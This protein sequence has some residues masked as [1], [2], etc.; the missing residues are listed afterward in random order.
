[1]ARKRP[2]G[3]ASSASRTTGAATVSFAPAKGRRGAAAHDLI[4]RLDRNRAAAVAAEATDDKEA[5]R[6]ALLLR[7]RAIE[8]TR[9][10]LAKAKAE[11]SV[12]VGPGVPMQAGEGSHAADEFDGKPG[13]VVRGAA[14]K[15][16]AKAKANQSAVKKQRT[17]KSSNAAKKQ[18]A[19]SKASSTAPTQ[20]TA[21]R[22]TPRSRVPSVMISTLPGEDPTSGLPR[23]VGTSRCP[24]LAF[25][26]KLVCGMLRDPSA[27]PFSAPVFQLWPAEAI[28]RYSEIV[29]RPMDLGT[30]KAR[31]DGMHYLRRPQAPGRPFST[32]ANHVATS[33]LSSASFPSG[34]LGSLPSLL[35]SLG[36]GHLSDGG[37][38]STDNDAAIGARK[39]GKEMPES[40]LEAAGVDNS[41]P[42][43]ETGF[44]FDL[45]A[46]CNDVRLCFNN[47]MLYCPVQEPLHACARALL[48]QFDRE[49]VN[50][51]VPVPIVPESKPSKKDRAA[52]GN[53]KSLN[54]FASGV[55]L[56]SAITDATTSSLSG[57]AHLDVSD[58]CS[59]APPKKSRRSRKAASTPKQ[60][61]RNPAVSV[62]PTEVQKNS[63][64]KLQNIRYL[65]RR[66]EYLNRCRVQLVA[67]ESGIDEVPLTHKEKARLSCRIGA[68][69]LDKVPQLVRMVSRASGQGQ[70]PENDEIEIDLDN[71][72]PASLREIER[73]VE[74]CVPHHI[75]GQP[76]SREKG[77]SGNDFDSLDAVEAEMRMVTADVE[78]AKAARAASPSGGGGL[79]DA[80]SSESSDDSSSDDDSLSG[81]DSDS[82]DA[83]DDDDDDEQ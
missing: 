15:T 66:L 68:V 65:K 53:A 54:G 79:W 38:T 70:V 64:P 17:A 41:R 39:E 27:R 45:V 73:F 44:I 28:P 37:Q 46:L 3:S 71:L 40:V 1:M 25:V 31:L 4:G 35:G 36:N 55:A 11:A 49:I 16:Q 43:R 51:P 56:S 81:S 29:V 24:T 58:G 69:P 57:G 9:A 18:A 42:T 72:P 50:C 26:R 6:S 14:T 62:C 7:L 67:R 20:P 77:G 5:K 23:C 10:A 78:R 19:A 8:E 82:S 32:G 83:D 52:S 34:S 13:S 21:S 48:D 60:D 59:P 47:C 80:S 61:S 22:R 33:P 12:S 75:G 2:R 76:I 74:G 30:V 63:K